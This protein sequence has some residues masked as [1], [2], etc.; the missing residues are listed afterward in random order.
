[1]RGTDTGL[2]AYLYAILPFATLIKTVKFL[3]T[4]RYGLAQVSDYLI[5]A[6]LI[7]GLGRE[8]VG[9]AVGRGAALAGAR[10]GV[11]ALV[12]LSTLSTLWGV[13]ATGGGVRDTI[14]F[15]AGAT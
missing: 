12:T 8:V 15:G 9:V 11:A 10:G 3:A 4:A 2:D 1:L 14:R 6:A 5:G 7:A 13:A